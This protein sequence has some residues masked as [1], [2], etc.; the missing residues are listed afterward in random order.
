[1]ADG[2]EGGLCRR[3]AAGP[4]HQ[5]DGI[6]L[7]RL[8]PP[9]ARE[10]SPVWKRHGTDR[11]PREAAR[12]GGDRAAEC[13]L[14]YGSRGVEV[15]TANFTLRKFVIG[16]IIIRR[17]R[18]KP[19]GWNLWSTLTCVGHARHEH[20]KRDKYGSVTTSPTSTSWPS[21]TSLTRRR[22]SKGINSRLLST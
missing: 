2:S 16:S 3:P 10:D 11:V 18:G 14:S 8:V 19:A 9:L 12:R 15:L 20:P 6:Y 4:L 22:N 13:T 5:L 17:C 1:M 21:S 7:P